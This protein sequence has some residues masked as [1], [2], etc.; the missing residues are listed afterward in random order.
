MVGERLPGGTVDILEATRGNYGRFMADNYPFGYGS[1]CV[2]YVD[3]RLGKKPRKITMH[4]VEITPYV[5]NNTSHFA[6]GTDYDLLLGEGVKL[7]I[8][9]KETDASSVLVHIKK[10]KKIRLLYDGKVGLFIN[11]LP[12]MERKPVDKNVID[13]EGEVND[14]GSNIIKERPISYEGCIDPQKMDTVDVCF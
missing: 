1:R 12:V 7:E 8:D 2:G 4:Q 10:G 3:V 9:G 14:A 6:A 11:P 13:M 5:F